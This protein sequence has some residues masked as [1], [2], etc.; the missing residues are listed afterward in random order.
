MATR[1]SSPPAPGDAEASDR[2][3]LIRDALAGSRFDPPYT[4]GGSAFLA[5]GYWRQDAPVTPPPGFAPVKLLGRQLGI[6]VGSSFDE[7]PAEL[8]IRYRE[9]IAA[10]VVRHGAS[11][12][13]MPFDMLLDEA[14]PVTLGRMH[15]GLPKRLDPSMFVSIDEARLHASGADMAIAGH[16]HGRAARA[17]TLPLRMMMTVGVR[18]LTRRIE[19]LG[20]ADGPARKAKIALTPRGAGRSF[21]DVSITF[22]STDLESL[23]CQSWSFT[24]T[25]LG[26]PR[27]AG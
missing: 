6:V 21:G 11:L 2:E 25:W 9:V 10:I 23:W 1:T 4:L 24:S 18:L 22:G 26:P 7:P 27:T 16:A 14:A 3:V 19:V 17:L 12:R 8:P 13:S 15:Y 5:L 20:T